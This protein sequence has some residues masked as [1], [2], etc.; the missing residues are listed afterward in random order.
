MVEL[1][2][3]FGS[4]FAAS[5]AVAVPAAFAWGVLSV[6]LSPCHLSS[7]PLVVAYMS[8]GE[9]LPAGRRALALSSAFAAGILASIALVGVLTAAAGRMLGDVGRAGNWILAGVFVAVGLNLLGLLPLPSFGSAP[10]SFRRRGA[11]GALLL[12]LVF[13]VALGPCTFAFMAPLLGIALRASGADAAGYGALLVLLYGLGHALAIALAGSS[14][15]SVN[16]W[17]AWKAGARAV[18]AVKG[19]AGVAVLL[20]GAWFAWTAP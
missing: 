11:P 9:E 10:S 12:G 3:A 17:L 4:A 19:L 7:V 15:Q 6:A 18:A 8:G 16:R 1:L 2:T 14:L 13:G 20:G 5:A